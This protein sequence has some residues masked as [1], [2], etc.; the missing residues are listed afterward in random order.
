MSILHMLPQRCTIY[1][2][3]EEILVSYMPS[4]ESW[5]IIEENVPCRYDPNYHYRSLG[6][7]VPEEM[8]GRDNALLFVEPNSPIRV[9]DI[10]V[11]TDNDLALMDGRQYDV[12][13]VSPAVGSRRTH[14]LEVTVSYRDNP[15]V[16]P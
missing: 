11:L 12:I 8:V 6:D 1:R 10:I 7:I 14:H 9:R 4:G 5:T 16:L 3:S 15:V 13:F 2:G